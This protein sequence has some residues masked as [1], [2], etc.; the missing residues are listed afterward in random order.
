MIRWSDININGETSKVCPKIFGREIRTMHVKLVEL[1]ASVNEKYCKYSLN[2]SN[3][4]NGEAEIIMKGYRRSKGGTQM[5][6]TK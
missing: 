1:M 6:G 5:K 2:L 3:E 4:R